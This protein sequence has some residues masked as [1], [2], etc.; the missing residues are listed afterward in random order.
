M[1]APFFSMRADFAIPLVW[2]DRRDRAECRCGGIDGHDFRRKRITPS[3]GTRVPT[4]DVLSLPL[5]IRGQR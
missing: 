5:I 3:R 1:L 4:D 2:P